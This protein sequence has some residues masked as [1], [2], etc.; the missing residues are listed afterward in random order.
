[1]VFDSEIEY[2]DLVNITNIPVNPILVYPYKLKED[3]YY[4]FNIA[5]NIIK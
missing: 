2:T 5:T 4:N 3:M 1:M